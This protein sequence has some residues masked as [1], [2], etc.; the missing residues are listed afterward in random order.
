MRFPFVLDYLF[1]NVLLWIPNN[2]SSQTDMA[3]VEPSIGRTPTRY[4]PCYPRRAR[5]FAVPVANRAGVRLLFWLIIRRASRGRYM[6]LS[7]NS[8]ISFQDVSP[9]VFSLPRL[10]PGLFFMIRP[11]AISVV[12]L[13]SKSASMAAVDSGPRAR[14]G[15]TELPPRVRR[16]SYQKNLPHSLH[17]WLSPIPCSHLHLQSLG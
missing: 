10:P 6:K 14:G 13:F 15:N 7:A 5:Y 16:S 17:S 8:T 4:I 2:T 12:R 9:F 11:A 3:L 1:F